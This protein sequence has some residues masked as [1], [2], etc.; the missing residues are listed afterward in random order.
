V[1]SMYYSIRDITVSLA[2][3]DL[4]VSDRLR[5]KFDLSPVRE[6]NT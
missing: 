1:V 4:E 2:A 5:G 3:L 6:N